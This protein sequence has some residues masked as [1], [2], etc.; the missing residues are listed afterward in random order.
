MKK[1]IPKKSDDALV[2]SQQ[3]Q[4]DRSDCQT[5]KMDPNIAD[6]RIVRIILR[7]L[8]E[9]TG[10]LMEDKLLEILKSYGTPDQTLVHVDTV[11]RVHEKLHF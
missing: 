5:I 1:E 10:F 8:A 2:H 7:R 3:I 9:K 6:N 11:F 4:S